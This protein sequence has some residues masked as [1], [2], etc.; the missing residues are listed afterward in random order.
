MHVF[1]CGIYIYIYMYSVSLV[2]CLSFL[3]CFSVNS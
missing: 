1:L 3:S 2:G